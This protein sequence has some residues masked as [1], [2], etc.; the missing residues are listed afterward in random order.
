M[1]IMY[2]YNDDYMNTTYTYNNC[3]YVYTIE[4]MYMFVRLCILYMRAYYNGD[5]DVIRDDAR[6]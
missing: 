5:D 2:V 1:N 3:I 4:Y 6:F